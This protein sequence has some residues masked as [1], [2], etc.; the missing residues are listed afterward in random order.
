MQNRLDQSTANSYKTPAKKNPAGPESMG[1]PSPYP[2]HYPMPQYGYPYPFPGPQP[3]SNHYDQ[4]SNSGRKT[5]QHQ[6]PPPGYP[7]PQFVPMYM[8]HP[9]YP[10]YPYF[11]PYMP[12]P[13][14]FMQNY[15]PIKDKSFLDQS[16]LDEIEDERSKKGVK[17]N[18]YKSSDQ[19]VAEF[20]AHT[21]PKLRLRRLVKMQAV[22]RGWYTRKFLIPRRRKMERLYRELT[23]KKINEFLE[24]RI[25]PDIVLEIVTMNKYNKDYTLY[26]HELRNYL[27][28]TDEVMNKFVRTACREI[29]RETTNNLAFE[30]LRMKKGEIVENDTNPFSLV[31]KSYIMNYVKK[32][33]EGIARESISDIVNEYLLETQFNNLMKIKYVPNRLKE[34]V[35]D[36]AKE[37]AIEDIL[38]EILNRM[39]TE[40][41]PAMFESQYEEV[42][43][44]VESAELEKGLQNHIRRGI[45]KSLMDSMASI[46]VMKAEKELIADAM[47][48]D[49]NLVSYVEDDDLAL[50]DN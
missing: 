9:G 18:T 16:G 15:S 14:N 21:L 50:G 22:M 37:V 28:I 38:D 10:G 31:A 45:L 13:Y 41:A 49:K 48:Q 25:I 6:H 40:L 32:H 46:I 20:K 12:Q 34:T 27:E 19:I 2:M 44:E 42:V 23:E 36:A 17:V 26:S 4:G 33:V 29:V 47:M 30:F 1:Y 39:I 11:P 5:A 24:D 35:E 7:G 43:Q 3:G 8:P